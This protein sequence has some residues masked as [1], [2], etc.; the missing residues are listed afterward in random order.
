MTES[1]QPSALQQVEALY[2]GNVAEKGVGPNSVGWRDESTQLLRFR[3]LAAIVDP[4]EDALTYND[5]G[6]GYGAMFPFLRDQVS[7]PLATYRGYDISRDM[8]AA[9]KQFTAD[10][11]ARVELIEAPALDRPADYSFVSGTFN[12]RFDA[13]DE[14][15]LQYILKMLANMAEHSRRG[16]A[17]NLLTSYVDWREP[18]LF[19]GDPSFF[20]D[21]LVRNVSRRVVLFHDYPLYEWT[22]GVR[23]G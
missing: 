20:V 4:T 17:F 2:T 19:Y 22:I 18:H 23:L 10:D 5:L 8:L 16:F 15:W 11:A 3:K 7:A 1:K 6:C 12:V 9:A 13:N 21:H 14:E